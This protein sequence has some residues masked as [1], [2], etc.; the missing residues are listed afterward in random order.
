MNLKNKEEL[1]LDN[2]S[3]SIYSTK[4]IY[5]LLYDISKVLKLSVNYEVV[6]MI[7]FGLHFPKTIEERIILKW[8]QLFQLCYSNRAYFTVSNKSVFKFKK[9]DS[10]RFIEEIILDYYNEKNK[11]RKGILLIYLS[12]FISKYYGVKFRFFNYI[13]TNVKIDEKNL[14]IYLAGVLENIKISSFTRLKCENV[15][16]WLKN[17]KNYFKKEHI[18]SLLLFGSIV[19]NTNILNSD[20]DLLVYFEEN[21]PQFEK[22]MHSKNIS[23][24][25]RKNFN[26]SCD[27]VEKNQILFD[28]ATDAF[29][30][31]IKIF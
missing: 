9:Y 1:F 13:F 2:F 29:E 16:E 31:A 27:I 21:V 26:C 12:I 30:T 25:I 23:E 22:E 19:K 28:G 8:Y 7:C 5:K 14:S 18:I 15:V 24:L 10:P 20:I 17:N 6:K 11:Y 4:D 3:N